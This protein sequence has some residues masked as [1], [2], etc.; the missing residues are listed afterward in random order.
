M[1]PLLLLHGALGAA[2]M[3]QPLQQALSEHYHVHTF[4]FAGHGGQPL[5]EEGLSIDFFAR[6]LHEYITAYGLQGVPVFGY[7]MGGYVALRL[8]KSHPGI[9]S[10]LITLATKFHWDPET[11]ARECSMLQPDKV[12]AK[13]PAFARALS[14]RHAPVNWKELMTATA[15]MLHAMGED[16]PLKPEDFPTFQLPVLLL[17]GDRDKMVG[18]EETLAVY[19]ALP[20]AAMGMLPGTPHPLEQA[21][22]LLLSFLIHRFLSR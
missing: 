9:I 18:L 4:S 1:Q 14:E 20:K 8:L 6:E 5:P 21:D 12:A 2:D 17:L 15:A 13:L 22:P 16:S 7:S 10:R 19:R 3:M 11:A